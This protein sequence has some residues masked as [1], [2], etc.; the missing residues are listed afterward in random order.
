MGTRYMNDSFWNYIKD[1]YE[2]FFPRSNLR[3]TYRDL[4]AKLSA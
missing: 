4:G 2:P 3:L 1:R